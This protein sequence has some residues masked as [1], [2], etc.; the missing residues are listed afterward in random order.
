MSAASARLCRR[1]VLLLFTAF[2]GHGLKCENKLKICYYFLAPALPLGQ[3]G[4]GG[5]GPPND[6]KLKVLR[7]GL[8]IVEN[9]GGHQ[10]NIF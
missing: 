1:S 5:G 10:E 8:P 4:T 2:P 7:M 3:G 9:L 6:E